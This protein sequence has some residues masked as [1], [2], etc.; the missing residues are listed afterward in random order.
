[1]PS[2]WSHHLNPSEIGAWNWITS[3]GGR[4]ESME[5]ESPESIQDGTFGTYKFS[6]L[7]MEAVL[8]LDQFFQFLDRSFFFS[9]QK[10]QQEQEQPKKRRRRRRRRRRKVSPNL[11]WAEENV[12]LRRTIFNASSVT[13]TSILPPPPPPP[14]CGFF[15]CCYSWPAEEGRRE[16]IFPSGNENAETLIDSNRQNP[17]LL[18]LLLHRTNARMNLSFSQRF[19]RPE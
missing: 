17:K 14:R 5:P 15:R 13:A 11:H 8:V 4:D 10:E 18:L 9:N 6:Y 12:S 7:W 16:N 3:P 19:N 1:M 2:T